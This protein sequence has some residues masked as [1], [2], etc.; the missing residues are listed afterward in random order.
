MLNSKHNILQSIR[1]VTYAK[2]R[3]TPGIDGVIVISPKQRLALFH[4]LRKEGW[5]LQGASPAL[6]IHL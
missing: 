4:E 6:R 5:A 1:K 2:G 3:K